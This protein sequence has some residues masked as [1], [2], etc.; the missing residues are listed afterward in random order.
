MDIFANPV[1]GYFRELHYGT[2]GLLSI[3][4]KNSSEKGRS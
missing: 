1:L 4:D 2:E 3:V